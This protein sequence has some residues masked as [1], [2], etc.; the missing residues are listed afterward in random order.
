MQRR[1]RGPILVAVEAGAKPAWEATAEPQN[2]RHLRPQSSPTGGGLLVAAATAP[3]MQ[4]RPPY[5]NR[6]HVP[7][8]AS[9]P[10]PLKI[11]QPKGPLW[12]FETDKDNSGG[13]HPKHGLRSGAALAFH[14]LRP[15]R[16]QPIG[17]SAVA[18]AA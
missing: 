9:S 15:P 6:I 1:L 3:L 13:K 11:W 12:A 7:Y 5:P 17:S 2:C 10:F 14:E 16:L 8:K 18:V 4:Q